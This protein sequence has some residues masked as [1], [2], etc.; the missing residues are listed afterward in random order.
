MTIK[1]ETP[2]TGSRAV[3]ELLTNGL[4]LADTYNKP[5]LSEKVNNFLKPVL[6]GALPGPWRRMAEYRLNK[7][8]IKMALELDTLYNLRDWL[9]VRRHYPR[10]SGLFTLGELGA[11]YNI[12]EINTL[13]DRSNLSKFKQKKRVQFKRS[14]FIKHI[15]GDT[16]KF[17]SMT[18]ALVEYKGTAKHTAYNV[19]GDVLKRPGAFLDACI[20]VISDGGGYSNAGLAKL[21]HVS[22]RRIQIATKENHET[23]FIEKRFNKVLEFYPSEKKAIQAHEELKA[24]GIESSTPFKLHKDYCITLNAV[25]AYKSH[26]L[27]RYKGKKD[28]GKIRAS[29]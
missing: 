20:G 23:G 16:Y 15:K 19:S 12:L 3:S 7:P 17:M 1:T 2:R 11:V 13:A 26:T 21:F 22:K 18:R 24:H 27:K 25:N 6:G 29:C 4:L 8:I 28:R 14:H 10:R 9:L 5:N